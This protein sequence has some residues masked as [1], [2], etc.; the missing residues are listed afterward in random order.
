MDGYILSEIYKF[1]CLSV[2]DGYPVLE[3]KREINA[4]EV[5]ANLSSHFSASLLFFLRS[6]TTSASFCETIP[7]IPF[8]LLRSENVSTLAGRTIFWSTRSIWE[9][10]GMLATRTPKF[11][12]GCHLKITPFNLERFAF[13]QCFRHFFVRGFNNPAKSWPRDFHFSRCLFLV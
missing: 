10:P 3:N 13:Y 7:G 5:T 12:N 11:S 8:S 4:F 9:F 2:N 6:T 1:H